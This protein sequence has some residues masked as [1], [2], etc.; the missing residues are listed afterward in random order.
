MNKRNRN[1]Y[2]VDQELAKMQVSPILDLKDDL[3][4][5]SPDFRY[6]RQVSDNEKLNGCP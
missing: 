2:E 3:L 1:C 4:N 6:A 5:I